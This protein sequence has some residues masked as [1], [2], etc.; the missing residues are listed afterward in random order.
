MIYYV[1]QRGTIDAWGHRD[2]LP[3]FDNLDDAIQHYQ[4]TGGDWGNRPIYDSNGSIVY[5]E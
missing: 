2:M 4:D 5:A 3:S 1:V